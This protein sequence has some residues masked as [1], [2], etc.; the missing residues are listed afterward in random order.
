MRV[1]TWDQGRSPCTSVETPYSAGRRG[2]LAFGSTADDRDGLVI[3]SP[4]LGQTHEESTRCRVS[5]LVKTTPDP[6]WKSANCKNDSRPPVEICQLQKTI[7]DPLWKS[8][9]RARPLALK[10]PT[11]AFAD[12]PFLIDSDVHVDPAR[13][14][15]TY[16]ICPTWYAV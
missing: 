4:A 2:R 5:L 10:S 12:S 3:A 16:T 14:L 11:A 15:A 8:I 1:A 7:P 13:C 6:L 9:Y